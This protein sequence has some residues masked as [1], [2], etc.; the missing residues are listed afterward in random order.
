MPWRFSAVGCVNFPL[1][2]GS[3]VPAFLYLIYKFCVPLTS[4]HISLFPKMND[5]YPFKDSLFM[6]FFFTFSNT[7]MIRLQNF[8]YIRKYFMCVYQ[9]INKKYIKQNYKIKSRTLG[10][11]F[12]Q[13]AVQSQEYCVT[14]YYLGL[15]KQKYKF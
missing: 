3:G 14:Y 7:L 5:N 11:V 1:P 9:S 8:H 4:K 6:Q 12:T 2:P 10:D 15:L 13:E